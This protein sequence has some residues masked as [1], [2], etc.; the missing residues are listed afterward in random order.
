MT[1]YT[2][3]TDRLRMLNTHIQRIDP[4]ILNSQPQFPE[5][6]QS[7]R[8]AYFQYSQNN[9]MNQNQMAALI[10]RYMISTPN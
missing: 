2:T 5:L 3:A 8:L 1:I 4:R 6:P 9:Q 7:E 10:K